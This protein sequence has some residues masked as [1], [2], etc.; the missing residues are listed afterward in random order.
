[1]KY[2]IPGL[3][4]QKLRSE[5][6]AALLTGVCL[7]SWFVY[8]KDGISNRIRDVENGTIANNKLLLAIAK[9]LDINSLD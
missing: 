9:K 1:M 4:Y 6:L 8:S 5:N 2:L 7:A 3:L